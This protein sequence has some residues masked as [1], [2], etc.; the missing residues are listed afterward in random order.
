MGV[1]VQNMIYY[2][3]LERNAKDELTDIDRLGLEGI[4]GCGGGSLKG[5]EGRGGRP[6]HE[7]SW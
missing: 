4:C 1:D 3:H 5:V 2:S 6:W 7:L